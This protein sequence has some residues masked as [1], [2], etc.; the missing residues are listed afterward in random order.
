MDIEKQQN[1]VRNHVLK[2]LDGKKITRGN[3]LQESNDLK[4]VAKNDIK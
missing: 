1:L 2:I 3:D 4:V